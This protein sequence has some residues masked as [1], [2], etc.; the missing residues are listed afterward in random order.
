MQA[1]YI[2]IKQNSMETVDEQRKI[3]EHLQTNIE[4]AKLLNAQTSKRKQI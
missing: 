4:R 3:D 2:F 1:L